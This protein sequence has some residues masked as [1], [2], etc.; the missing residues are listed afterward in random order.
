MASE[1]NR[2]DALYQK[3]K[4][5]GY[6]SR[7][8]YKLKELDSK[9]GLLKSGYKVLDLGAWPGG[10]M[11]VAQERVGAVGRIVGIDLVEIEDFGA[12]NIKVVK[13]DARDEENLTK[14]TEFAG[15]PF[16][17]VLSDM[18][19]KLTGIREVDSA[20]T[21]ACA[22]LALFIAGKV[23]LKG[24]NLVM[25]VFKSNDTEVFVKSLRPLFNKVA[26]SE[27]D[28][29]RKTSNEFYLIA[30]GFSGRNTFCP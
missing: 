19:P 8:A 4:E 10:W 28:S 3:A 25:K 27:L 7:A 16:N 30:L 6:R 20:Q 23:L 5:E 26:R 12:E 13:G 22:E 17:L 15:G 29:T 18:S 11:Q 2:K 24:G 21:V 9:Y 14:C 1:Y